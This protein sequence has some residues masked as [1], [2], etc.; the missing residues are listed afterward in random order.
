MTL[1]VVAV[2]A[3]LLVTGAFTARVVLHA[4]SG[5]APPPAATASSPAS[6]ASDAR[7]PR[8]GEHPAAPSPSATDAA[9]AATDVV[10]PR[11]HGTWEGEIVQESRPQA[12]YEVTFVLTERG[13]NDR[14]GQATYPELGCIGGLTL[15]TASPGRL[16]VEQRLTEGMGPCGVFVDITFTLLDDG[17]LHCSF[18]GFN[19]AAEGVLRKTES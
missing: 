15:T 3:V 2:L 5:K 17:S 13:R 11:L 7:S 8:T 14:V 1:S 6:T 10:D 19:Y 4:S 16:V 18:R 9:K 12:R